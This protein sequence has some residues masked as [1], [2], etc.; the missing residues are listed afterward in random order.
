MVPQVP[1]MACGSKEEWQ[2]NNL[3]GGTHVELLIL[4]NPN[5]H[6]CPPQSCITGMEGLGRLLSVLS[7]TG[8]SLQE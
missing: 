8:T 1:N 7:V 6:Q 4:P 3:G 2:R 5:S